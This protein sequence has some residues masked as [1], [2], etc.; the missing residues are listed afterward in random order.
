M[1]DFNQSGVLLFSSDIGHTRL[2][3]ISVP[4]CLPPNGLSNVADDETHYNNILECGLCGLWVGE[5]QPEQILFAMLQAIT[6]ACTTTVRCA[7]VTIVECTTLQPTHTSLG[8]FSSTVLCRILVCCGWSNRE[9]S[10][11]ACSSGR[12]L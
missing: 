2:C 10:A 8:R 9:L 1:G 12:L 6:R 7:R 11:L 4:S 5:L 3:R